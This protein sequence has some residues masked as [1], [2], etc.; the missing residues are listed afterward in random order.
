MVEEVETNAFGET[1][2]EIVERLS[3]EFGDVLD[4]DDEALIETWAFE[5]GGI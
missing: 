3:S 1:K 4:C 5:L 2:E